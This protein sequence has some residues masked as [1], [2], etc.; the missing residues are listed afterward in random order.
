VRHWS[1]SAGANYNDSTSQGNVLGSY[2]SYSANLSA[3]RQVARW[4]H[5]IFGFT[6][7]KYT[8]GDFT[9]YNKWVYSVNVGLSFS[10]GDVPIRLW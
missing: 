4:T 6:A 1:I 8:S 2:G 9:N 5:G 7:R 10:P 3:S